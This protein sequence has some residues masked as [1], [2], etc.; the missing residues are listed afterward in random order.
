MSNIGAGLTLQIDG[1]KMR[2]EDRGPADLVGV[3]DTRR[4]S[5]VAEES[6]KSVK[7][8]KLQ[9]LESKFGSWFRGLEL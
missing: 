1:G 4:A 7:S 3:G 9:A 5:A 6:G 2:T 8:P